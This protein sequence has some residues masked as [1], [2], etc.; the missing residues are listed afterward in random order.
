MIK[1][2]P[3]EEERIIINIYTTNSG[4]SRYIQQII[5]DLKGE[6]IDNNTVVVGDF[7]TTLLTLERS[8]RQ[9]IKNEMLKLSYT[10]D[11]MDLGIY[12]N[13]VQQQQNIHYSRVLREHSPGQII[14]YGT[15][16]RTFKKI[17]IPTIFSDHNDIN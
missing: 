12:R 5:T 3:H 16:L 15:N 10:L 2:S 17:E 11:Q 14:C 8:S 7:N 6:I 1:G 4:A 9:I 13:S